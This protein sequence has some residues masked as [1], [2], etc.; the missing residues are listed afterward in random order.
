MP[1]GALKEALDT[2]Y[3]EIRGDV[4]H[5]RELAHE[6]EGLIGDL[7][8]EE[9]IGTGLRNALGEARK[10]LTEG[11]GTLDR[12]LKEHLGKQKEVPLGTGE[13]EPLENEPE[14]PAVHLA[15]SDNDVEV[16]PMPE[17]LTDG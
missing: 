5:A 8:A 10:H 14:E 9:R 2:A 16:P 11:A 1:N 15:A 17:V 12:I 3:A 4:T 6:A 13:E 7:Q